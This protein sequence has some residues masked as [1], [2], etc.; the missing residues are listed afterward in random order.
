MSLFTININHVLDAETKKM[1]V[2]IHKNTK[3]IMALVEQLEEKIGALQT[4][5]DT[6]Q[7]VA[8][9]KVAELNAVITDLQGQIANGATPEQLQ[10]LLDKI[11][12]VKDDLE[13]TT[14]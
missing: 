6:F 2:E 11:T 14:L 5:V 9:S 1:L 13:A 12:V 8:I 7:E 4:S 10:T 3:K